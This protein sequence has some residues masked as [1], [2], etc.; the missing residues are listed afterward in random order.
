MGEACCSGDTLI[1][2]LMLEGIQTQ[3]SVWE[4]GTAPAGFH[5]PVESDLPVLLMAGERDSVT[6]PH[7]AAQVAET[8]PNSLNLVA[9]GQSHSVMK[10]ICLQE[11]TT[12]FIE[13]GSVED[14][15]IECVDDIRPAPFFTSLLGP[16]P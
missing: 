4:A 15:D 13:Q 9:R 5:E 2:N 1:G 16:D 8:F 7:Y 6:P 3:C 11:V 12:R 10:L 14:L